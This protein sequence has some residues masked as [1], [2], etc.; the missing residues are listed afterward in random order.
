MRAEDAEALARQLINDS[1]FDEKTKESLLPH[2]RK[3]FK[4]GREPE[5]D[6]EEQTPRDRFKEILQKMAG[7][8]SII[9]ST[10]VNTQTL[11]AR[12]AC[13]LHGLAP[14][15]VSFHS[16]ERYAGPDYET[17]WDGM[18]ESE[19]RILQF[20]EAVLKGDHERGEG[21]E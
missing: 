19:E 1:P 8:L 14:G 15:Q 21:K 12:P 6:Q 2:L 13:P 18:K 17:G 3:L 7:A 10:C 9:S 16:D 20:C 11:E 5:N 4:S